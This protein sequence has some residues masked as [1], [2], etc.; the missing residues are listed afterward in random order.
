VG[1]K[2]KSRRKLEFEVLTPSTFNIFHAWGLHLDDLGDPSINM[3]VEL[4]RL[5]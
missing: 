2:K 4:V 5:G 3:Y 1:P